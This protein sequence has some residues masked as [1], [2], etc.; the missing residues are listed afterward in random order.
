MINNILP[1]SVSLFTE[2]TQIRSVI[3]YMV[4]KLYICLCARK[5]YQFME[6]VQDCDSETLVE[7]SRHGFTFCDFIITDSDLRFQD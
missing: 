2:M 6:P 1:D 3:Q 7:I 5:S 4:Y